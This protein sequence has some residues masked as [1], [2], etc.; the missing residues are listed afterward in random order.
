MRVR[1]WLVR[2][3][4]LLAAA[5]AVTAAQQDSNSGNFVKP[6]WN[7]FVHGGY[8]NHGRLVLQRAVTTVP[9][10][11]ERALRG[12]GGFNV[13][14]GLGVD[15]LTR[16]GL[17]LSYTYASTDLAFRQDDGDDSE[18]L[19]VEDVGKLRSHVVSLEAVRFILNPRSAVAPYG[20]AGFVGAWWQLK[21]E[22]NLVGATDKDT[23][24]RLGAIG[25][26]GVKTRVTDHFDFRFEWS[27][28]TVRN[29][30]GGRSSFSSFGGTTIDEPERVGKHDLRLAAVYSFGNTRTN[31]RTANG[32]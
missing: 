9:G 4:F 20:S 24:F 31:G 7:L 6:N 21:D 29:P 14:G 27:S 19:D 25:T 17:R 30:F 28:A 32:R 11:G 15:F 13:G 1:P 18:L 26:L 5:P 10:A 2:G 3:L 12:D 22:T 23:Q 8:S 16:A